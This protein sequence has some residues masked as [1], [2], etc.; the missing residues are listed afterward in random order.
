MLNAD[1]SGLTT[2]NSPSMTALLV[3]NKD[4]TYLG[5]G[6]AWKPGSDG[7][8][9]SSLVIDCTDFAGTQLGAQLSSLSFDQQENVIATGYTSSPSFDR[10]GSIIAVAQQADQSSPSEVVLLATNGNL[11]LDIGA[12]GQ[13]AFQP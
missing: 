13:P 2:M 7:L 1:G 11:V 5:W 3:P 12:G 8:I 9:I 10:S 6:Y 4:I